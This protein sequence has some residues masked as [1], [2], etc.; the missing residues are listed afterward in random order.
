MYT[1]YNLIS[2]IRDKKKQSSGS[3]HNLAS[4]KKYVL[5]E[6]S[7]GDSMIYNRKI[8]SVGSRAL[9]VGLKTK[10]RGRILESRIETFFRV[11]ETSFNLTY[12]VAKIYQAG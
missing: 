2:V 1:G 3:R 4:I 8:V 12:T 11:L 7:K 10:S 6:G 5:S 9:S